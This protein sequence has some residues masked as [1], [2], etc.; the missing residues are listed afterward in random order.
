M[1]VKLG[2]VP[3]ILEDKTYVPM[4]FIEEIL[5]AEVEVFLRGLR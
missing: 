2:I 4:N 3:V 1:F 5:K